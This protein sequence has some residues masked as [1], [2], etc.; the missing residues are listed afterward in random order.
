MKAEPQ[1]VWCGLLQEGQKALQKMASKKGSILSRINI[2]SFHSS[3]KVPALASQ[4]GSSRSRPALWVPI[5]GTCNIPVSPAVCLNSTTPLDGAPC[6]A[7]VR[8]GTRGDF[9]VSA[10]GA[11]A[12]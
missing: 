4:P 6:V 11:Q 5:Y 1:S 12:L 7:A 3:T 9:Q 2:S 8:G 10:A